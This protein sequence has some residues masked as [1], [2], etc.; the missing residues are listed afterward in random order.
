MH[1]LKEFH[2]ATKKKNEKYKRNSVRLKKSQTVASLSI[3]STASNE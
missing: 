3:V 2:F 1:E